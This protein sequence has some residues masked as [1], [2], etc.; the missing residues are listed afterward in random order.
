MMI[1]K[2]SEFLILDDLKFCLESFQDC[3]LFSVL[4]FSEIHFNE[5]CY[6]NNPSALYD[7]KFVEFDDL[8]LLGD[9]GAKY[10]TLDVYRKI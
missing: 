9:I 10:L 1:V 4:M 8:H 2:S 7:V 6:R 3:N 5:L